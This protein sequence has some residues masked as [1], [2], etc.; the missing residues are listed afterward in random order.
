MKKLFLTTSLLALASG[1]VFAADPIDVDTAF[2][3][4]GVY[5]GLNAGY[6]FGGDD[7]VGVGLDPGPDFHDV[8]D[9]D[10]SGIFGGL[11]AGWNWQVD[12]FVLGLEGDIQFADIDGDFSS[13][14]GLGNSFDGSSDVDFFGTARLRAGW[15]IDQVLF[16]GTAGLA[17]ADLDYSV[18]FEGANGDVAN[19]SEDGGIWGYAVGGGAEFA[20]SEAL[21]AKVEYLYIGLDSDEISGAVRDARGGLTGQDATTVMTPSFHTVR[22]GLNWHF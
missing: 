4:S 16:Y 1:P 15:A 10:M 8:G 2:D 9:V 13:T 14:D 22:V 17:W 20:F 6:A 7:R 5:I 19:M 18:R 21:S 12:S 3:W 11:Q